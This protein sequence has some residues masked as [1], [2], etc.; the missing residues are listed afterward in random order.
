MKSALTVKRRVIRA[1]V[2]DVDDI[3]DDE[4]SLPM[5]RNPRLVMFIAAGIL[6]QPRRSASSLD[7]LIACAR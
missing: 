4:Q 7:T 5:L 6:L 2:V 3:A 1:L